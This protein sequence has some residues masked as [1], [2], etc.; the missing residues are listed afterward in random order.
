[1]GMRF[2]EEYRKDIE[3]VLRQVPQSNQLANHSLLLTGVTGMIVSTIADVLL[4]YNRERDAHL[5]L[6]FA[7]RNKERVVNRFPLYQEGIDYSFVYFDATSSDELNLKVDYIINGASHADPK[8]FVSQP[9]ETML[10]SLYGVNILLRM[11]K[12][13]GAKRFLQISSSEVY[14][15]KETSEPYGETEY[16][17]VDILNPRA[18]Y[19]CAKR[20]ADTLCVSYAA[21]YGVDVVMIRPGHIYGPSITLSDSRVSSE[22]TRLAASGKNL[23]MKSAGLQMRSYC[24]T[25]DCASAILTV[26]L[27]GESSTVYNISNKESVVTIREMAEAFAEAGHV[28]LVIEDATEAEKKGYNLMNN[29]SLDGTRL[30][31]LG[32][33]ALF[34]MREGAKRTLEEYRNGTI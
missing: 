23:T 26:L 5:T 14:G 25:L 11:A 21:E 22:F 2:T 24:H 8:S 31:R 29:S 12:K 34:G 19:P 20:A 6:Y 18:C 10:A 17:F 3:R 28:K 4:W 33:K 16:G 1:M 27:N 30:E 32:W 9:V 13:Q 15:K 7:G